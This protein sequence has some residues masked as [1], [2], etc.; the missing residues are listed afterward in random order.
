MGDVDGAV[1]EAVEKDYRVWRIYID[2][3]SST[4]NI[5]PLVE[6]WQGRWSEQ[7]VIKWL[8][9]RP[10]QT[11]FAVS[12]YTAAINTATLSHN[13]DELFSRHVKNATRWKVT[14]RDDKGR[15]L[16]IIGKEQPDSPNKIDAAAAGVLS[17][18]ARGDAIAADAQPSDAIK[19][20]DSSVYF[21]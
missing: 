19:G 16:H 7:K 4:G 15:P 2:P 8:M 3:G 9:S 11:A 6:K 20:A 18:E 10:K 14:A 17:W 13:G 5:D 12:N 21:L 1:T